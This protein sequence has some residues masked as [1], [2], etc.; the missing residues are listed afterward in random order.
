MTARNKQSIRLFRNVSYACKGS[1]CNSGVIFK[2]AYSHLA[3][4]VPGSL[5]LSH[6]SYC[7]RPRFLYFASLSYYKLFILSRGFAMLLRF[8]IRETREHSTLTPIVPCGY[9][10]V[11]RRATLPRFPQ[12]SVLDRTIPRILCL[13]PWAYCT[14]IRFI[15]VQDGVFA[16]QTDTEKAEAEAQSERVQDGVFAPCQNIRAIRWRKSRNTSPSPAYYKV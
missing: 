12:P 10:K 11:V 16:H 8:L 15:A 5:Q 13:M 3:S 6:R 2:S 7:L 4:T 1:A 14:A 9:C